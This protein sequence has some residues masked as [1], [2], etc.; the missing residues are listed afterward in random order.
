MRANR[1]CDAAASDGY[2]GAEYNPLR[3]GL[4][5]SSVHAAF[6]LGR[7]LHE[8]GRSAPR[9]VR[10][11]R[12]DLMHAN[13]MLWRLDWSSVKFPTITREA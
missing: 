11:G 3:H 8:T 5:T 9:D 4:L 2:A 10:P 13:D 6:C 7:H 1:E 12:G